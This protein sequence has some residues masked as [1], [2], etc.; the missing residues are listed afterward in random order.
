MTAY[1]EALSR[2]STEGAPWF[3]IPSNH[4]WFRNLA[5]ARILVEHLEGLK[6]TYPKP[7]VDLERIRRDYHAAKHGH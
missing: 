4:K 7:A 1:E 3:V 6:L 2:C 5:V